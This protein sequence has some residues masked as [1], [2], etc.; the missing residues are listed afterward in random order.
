MNNRITMLRAGAV[1]TV[2]GAMTFSALAA[3]DWRWQPHFDYGIP[4]LRW[5]PPIKTTVTWTDEYGGWLVPYNTTYTLPYCREQTITPPDGAEDIAHYTNRFRIVPG[6]C[7]SYG[8]TKA[9]RRLRSDTWRS[10]MNGFFN[11][12]RQDGLSSFHFRSGFFSE[13]VDEI[14]W[15]VDLF[16]Y[17]ASRG[18]LAEYVPGTEFNVVDGVCDA[19]PGYLFST[20]PIVFNVETGLTMQGTGFTGPLV[21]DTN[22]GI[23]PTPGSWALVVLAVGISSRRRR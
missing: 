12:I 17:Y 11:M 14:Y 9:L 23:C 8:M 20:S 4:F 3:P 6:V 7:H 16:T 13:T 21:S 18:G 10:D 1:A 19:L 2:L 15:S 22:E 5:L